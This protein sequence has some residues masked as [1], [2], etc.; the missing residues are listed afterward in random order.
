M[1][2]KSE[3]YMTGYTDCETELAKRI[4]ELEKQVKTLKEEKKSLQIYCQNYME[5]Y[6]ND[7]QEAK[8]DKELAVMQKNDL[9]E[10]FVEERNTAY[11]KGYRAGYIECYENGRK[12]NY[13]EW[14]AQIAMEQNNAE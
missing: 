5:V 14:I 6:Y 7:L 10:R 8:R 4:A 13:D 12:E 3:E 2:E 1:T 11:C 9:R